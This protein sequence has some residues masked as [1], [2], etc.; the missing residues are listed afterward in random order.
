MRITSFYY[1]AY[2]DSLP[3]DPL[4]AAN[5]VYLEVSEV[6]GSINDFDFTYS[7][8]IYTVGFIQQQV[9]AKSFFCTRPAIVVDRFDDSSIKAAL[10]AILPQM[11]EIAERK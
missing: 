4:V 10:E 3:L 8:H 2:P 7:I 11:D 1:L 9:K 5:E 6:E